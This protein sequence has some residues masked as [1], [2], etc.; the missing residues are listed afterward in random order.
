MFATAP[1]I[2][3]PVMALSVM[4]LS[5][6]ALSGCSLLEPVPASSPL[7]SVS[8]SPTAVDTTKYIGGLID[9]DGT[10]WSGKDSGGDVTTL[11]L[12]SD[13]TVAVSYGDNAYDDP[14]DVWRVTD[15]VLY[16]TVHIDEQNGDAHYVG[17]WDPTKSVLD[18]VMRTTRTALEL[19][20]TLTQK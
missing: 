12:H 17:T 18:A 20:V 1:A 2:A 5:V 19:T 10:V 11:T 6:M 4:A 16:L 15:G 8:P 3:L 9:P 7:T 14:N 13:G